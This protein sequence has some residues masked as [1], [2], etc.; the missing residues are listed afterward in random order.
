VSRKDDVQSLALLYFGV[1]SLKSL[2]FSL[3]YSAKPI[4]TVKTSIV[5]TGNVLAR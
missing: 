1:Q 3:I 5:M 4:M 2:V